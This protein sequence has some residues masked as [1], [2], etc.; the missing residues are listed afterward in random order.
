V[1]R[2]HWSFQR[3]SVMAAAC[4]LGGGLVTLCWMCF[5]CCILEWPIPTVI[6]TLTSTGPVGPWN[7]GGVCCRPIVRLQMSHAHV[8]RNGYSNPFYCILEGRLLQV[9]TPQN[10]N[11]YTGS[12]G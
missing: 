11:L 8:T 1:L 10:G 5:G 3:D 6:V 12:T 2:V 7:Q 4:P 9:D